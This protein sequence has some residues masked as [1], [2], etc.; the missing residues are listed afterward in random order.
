MGL[1]Q[2]EVEVSITP[3]NFER[4]KSLGYDIDKPSGKLKVKTEDLSIGSGIKVLVKCNY[5]GKIFKKAYRRYIETKDDICCEECK[6]KKMM[7]T[8]KEKYGYSCS[9]KNK[10]VDA[11]R[12]K[13]F[14]EKY[15]TTNPFANKEIYQKTRESFYK[16]TKNV[17][18]SIHAS[19]QQRHIMNLYGAEIN[20]LFDIYFVDGYLDEY[21]IYI[22]YDGSGHKLSVKMGE[23]TEQEYEAKE[24]NRT[25]RLLSCGIKEF[26]I[27][28]PDDNIPSDEELLK[29]K[30]F[31]I[32]KLNNGY[33]VCVYNTISKDWDFIEE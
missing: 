24:K 21:K 31:A 4:Y 12:K 10:E 8:S 20:K 3:Y 14:M 6:K 7:K 19:K 9:L 27:V 30:D 11:K 1:V 13:T 5:C 28:C 33:S 18:D 32:D 29:I 15:G 25:D 23:I 22:E 26:R 17:C 2:K 16:N